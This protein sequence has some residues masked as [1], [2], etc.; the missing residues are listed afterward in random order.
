MNQL[1]VSIISCYNRQLLVDGSYGSFSSSVA[2][3][4]VCVYLLPWSSERTSFV[5]NS[6]TVTQ[7]RGILKAVHGSEAVSR[8]GVD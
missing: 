1:L 6:G 2:A 4:R 7:T 8:S 3:P 5:L